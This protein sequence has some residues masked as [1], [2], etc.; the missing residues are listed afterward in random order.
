MRPI[1][2]QTVGAID[3]K[4]AFEII[5]SLGGKSASV[6][7]NDKYQTMSQLRRMMSDFNSLDAPA[8][9]L[10]LS[11]WGGPP[12]K[13]DWYRGTLYNW[14]LDQLFQQEIDNQEYDLLIDFA[15]EYME[16]PQRPAL[17]RSTTIPF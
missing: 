3:V 14:M 15:N 12:N 11:F 1:L 10:K 6:L 16:E 2:Y 9:S 8:A 5:E 17:K 13:K 4:A 7:F